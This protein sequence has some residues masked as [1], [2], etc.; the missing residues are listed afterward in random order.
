[1]TQITDIL[2]VNPGSTSTKIAVFRDGK[3]FFEESLM[4][5]PDKLLGFGS[6]AGQMDYRVQV[7]KEI[8]KEKNYDIKTLAA[9]VGR[10]GMIIGLKGGGYL[11]NKKLSDAMASPDI[12]QHAS[13]LG[14]MIAFRIGESI[15][16]PAYI[17]DSTMGCELID[18]A[19][20]TGIAGLEKYGCCHVLNSHAQAMKYAELIGRKY[21]DLNL[22]VCHMGGGITAC[23][24]SGGKIVD[25]AAYDD[26]PMAP[27]RSGGVPL[28]LFKEICFDGKH[29][30]EDIDKLI[31]GKGGLYSYLGTTNCIDIEKRI[32][33]GD[34]EA[35]LVYKAMA[36][37][38]GKAIAG[39]SAPLHGKV[40]AVILTGGVAHSK[41]LTDMI[42][43]YAGHIGKFVVMAGERELE[44][45]AEGA[46]RM[47]S[48]K[49]EAHVY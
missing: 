43:D 5:D 20:I 17:Y 21:E 3:E 19:K 9:V 36:Y 10:G 33:E 34:A 37:Q 39:L 15:G 24:Q 30:E 32:A 23:A 13:S 18:V 35:E 6:I 29:T 16:I 49:E 7:I 1:M 28:L 46:A 11:V 47:L 42:E 2:V 25:T 22:I 8:L 4:H 12:P 48:G 44:A 26:G 45:L 14:A 31:S 27:E 40:D 38:I 41:M